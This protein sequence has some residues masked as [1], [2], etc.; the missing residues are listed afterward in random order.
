[1][2]AI[3]GS[4]SISEQYNST[5]IVDNCGK[6]RKMYESLRNYT[7]DNIGIKCISENTFMG[8][9][10]QFLTIYSGN[11]KLPVIDENI[12]FNTDCV[13]DNRDELLNK[14]NLT[15]NTMADS[16]IMYYAYRKWGIDCVKYIR[17]LFSLAVYEIN[18]QILYLAA[19]PL[20]ARC[21]YYIRNNDT[22]T[23]STLLKPIAAI[24]NSL[25]RNDLYFKD[26]L[27]APGLMPNIS[28]YETP[29]CNV[30][31]MLPGTYI[32]F[33]KDSTQKIKYY[34]ITQNAH[35][36]MPAKYTPAVCGKL[37]RSILESAVNDAVKCSKNKV[38]VSLS[39]GLDSASVGVLAA[40]EL[41]KHNKSLN[42]YTY[43][44]YMKNSQ[45]TQKNDVIDET[46]DVMKIVSMHQNIIPHFLTNEGRNCLEDL[47]KC[48]K[49]ME[50]PIKAFVNMPNLCEIYR[51]AVCDGSSVILSG[52]MGNSTISHGY[53][54]DI[55]Y[56]LFSNKKYLKFACWLNNYSKTVKE[57]RKQALSGCIKYFKYAQDIYANH[58]FAYKSDNLYLSDKI[59]E[60]YNMKQR[61][62]DGG[63]E[64][65]ESVPTSEE[66]YH[67]N[68]IKPAMLAYLGEFETKMGLTHH[69]LLRDPTKDIR[70]IEFCNSI[71]YEY[72]AY[73]GTPRWFVRANMRD[74]LPVGLLDDWLRYG[75]QNSDYVNRIFRD[76]DNAKKII[77]DILNSRS[78]ENMIDKD[79]IFNDLESVKACSIAEADRKLSYIVSACSAMLI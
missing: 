25:K 10:T 32:K 40:D 56:H 27:T 7:F 34:D 3:W 49:Y 24:E 28:P 76:W 71:P 6:Q 57:S 35:I 33:T 26:F 36:D 8:C 4:V 37:F 11:E 51:K 45:K 15:D 38:A 66:F 9:G 17:G 60:N 64:F 63:I 72:F 75:L 16:T 42:A 74:V 79:K 68:I 50:I 46:E 20:S 30:Y 70:V 55:L 54:D 62:L 44:P 23:F 47:E 14:L 21:L 39:S 5:N 52:Q 18:R 69:I 29:Y 43:V 22:I 12:I 67:D 78:F 65:T 19:D 58:E 73:K 31:K 1:M 2:S 61:Y 41:K 53:I 48:V 59:Y 77:A 13:I